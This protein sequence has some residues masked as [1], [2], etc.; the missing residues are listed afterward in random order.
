[1]I[2]KHAFVGSKQDKLKTSPSILPGPSLPQPLDE[3]NQANQ[4]GNFNKRSHGSRKRLIAVRAVRGNGDSDSKFEIVTRGRK[5]LCRSESVSI[6]KVVADKQGEEEDDEKVDYEGCG[7]ADD[8]D[9]LMNDLAAL[10]GEEN[11]DGVEKADQGP[12]GNPF[13]KDFFVPLWAGQFAQCEARKNG[14]AERYAQ[15]DGHASCY[16]LIRYDNGAA[17]AADDFDE[18]NGQWSIEDH[19]ENRIDRYEDGAVFLITAGQS[20]PD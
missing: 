11:K 20:V 8:R 5:A 15:K 6:P 16:R 10:R 1:M 17:F 3:I 9:D 12:R 14:G 19:L 2:G 7:D 4:H 18:E 13:Q